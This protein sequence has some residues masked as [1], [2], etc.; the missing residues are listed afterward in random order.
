M[1]LKSRATLATDIATQFATNG[2][3]AITATVLRNYST[4]DVDSAF[5][6]T[7]DTSDDITEGASNLFLTATERAKIA[8][9]WGTYVL[10]GGG[11]DFTAGVDNVLT[12]P[13]AAPG[14]NKGNVLVYFEG[15]PQHS[16]QWSILGTTMTFT[17]V[18]PVGVNAIELR[19]L[20]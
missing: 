1:P 15:A 11:V 8:Q 18:I 10:A 3:Q 2:V 17:S 14:D 19:I 16:D 13:V 4:D 12:M 6:L 20:A 5:N 7:D 9:T